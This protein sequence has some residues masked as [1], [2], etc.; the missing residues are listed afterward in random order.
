MDMPNHGGD[1]EA[2]GR[3]IEGTD[4]SL[5]LAVFHVL[6]R[7]G[8]EIVQAFYA[9]LLTIEELSSFFTHHVIEHQ[10]GWVLRL[11]L[12]ELFFFPRDKDDVAA[13]ITRQV[14]VGKRHA[15]INVPL[16]GIQ[17]AVAVLKR[18]LFAHVIE[19]GLESRQLTQ[20]ILYIN[21]MV[22][23]AIG[24][25][26]RICVRDMLSDVRDQQS[27][28]LQVFSVDMALQTESLRASLFDW[29]RQV[30]RLL[31][32]E[33]IRA[34]CV[35]T[36]RRTNLGLWIQHKG[37]LMLPDTAEI[38]QLKHIIEEIDGQLKRALGSRVTVPSTDLRGTLAAIDQYVNT[39]ASILGTISDRM[40]TLEGGRDTLT[41]LF[42]RRF[43]R[44]ILQREVRMSVGSGERF[45]LIMV[46]IDYFKSIND[47]YGH[48][49][50]D[51]V[52]RQFAELLVATTRAGDFVF[53]YGGEEFLVL[54][55]CVESPSAAIVAE[56]L[57]T[58]I[59]RH[60]F[61]MLDE[62]GYNITASLGVAIHDGHP[63]YGRVIDQA[64][65]A[66]LEAKRTGRNRWVLFEPSM[67]A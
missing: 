27:L 51:G 24:I 49:A 58:A 9:E 21:G 54:V 65:Q 38:R 42:N 52:L 40:L 25:T 7:H 50:G 15:V 17:A 29:H 5:R 43:L 56:K 53:R 2:V 16:S 10:L 30:L 12:T 36:L 23:W 59:D 34:D 63:D 55:T 67:V 6:G 3:L 22:D 32:D 19:S 62:R 57:R 66:L 41:K 4:E 13:L 35:P 48:T 28:K 14:E 44:A 60:R 47:R 46:D 64:D 61:N 20:A 39:A 18:E 26:N 1:A 37:E 31:Y 33:E 45:A 11:W 8:A